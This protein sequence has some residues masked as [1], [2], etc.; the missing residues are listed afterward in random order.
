MLYAVRYE[1]TALSRREQLSQ[2]RFLAESL[3]AYALWQEQGVELSALRRERT[4]E[5]KPYFPD[6]SV[7]FNVSHC[8][9]LVCCALSSAPVG[10]DGEGP[11]PVREPLLRRACTE[12][13]LRWLASQPD[14]T[15]A[16]LSL[17][18][19]KESVLK[20]TGQGLK[21]GLRNAAFSFADGAPRF[22]QG[23]V[24]LSQHVLPGGY[25]ISAASRQERFSPPQML[26]RSELAQKT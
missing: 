17:W 25:L 19:L 3:L 5:G 11:R 7:H 12:E 13:E 18:T 6:S 9:G 20:L 16:F 26:S 2:Q 22:I 23:G 8:R 21:Y 1:E 4:P 15:A 10:V 14:R 24:L